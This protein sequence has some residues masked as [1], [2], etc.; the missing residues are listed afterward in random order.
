MEKW[1]KMNRRKTVLNTRHNQAE[2]KLNG[3]FVYPEAKRHVTDV[4]HTNR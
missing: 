2:I 4:I 3:S 1:R